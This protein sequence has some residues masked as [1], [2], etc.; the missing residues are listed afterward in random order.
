MTRALSVL[1]SNSVC[2]KCFLSC[3][4]TVLYYEE[5]S[6]LSACDFRSFLK[7]LSVLDVAVVVEALSLIRILEVDF[8][9]FTGSVFFIKGSSINLGFTGSSHAHSAESEI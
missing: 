8:F 9:F 5:I 7:N 3:S 6:D 1:I 2:P 4:D